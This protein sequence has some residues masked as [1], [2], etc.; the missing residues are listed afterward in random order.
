VIVGVV[1]GLRRA[2]FGQLLGL[3]D[4]VNVVEG[5]TVFVEVGSLVDKCSGPGVGASIREVPEATAEVDLS[6][7]VGN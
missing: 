5:A 4:T 7:L 1:G 3:I 2:G 6:E